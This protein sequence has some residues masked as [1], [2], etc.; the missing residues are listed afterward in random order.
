MRD[1]ISLILAMPKKLPTAKVAGK[2]ACS[3]RPLRSDVRGLILAAREQVARA[4]DSGLVTLYWHIGRR[5]HQDILKA[6]RAEYGAEI[7]ATLSRQLEAEFGRGFAEK[8]LRRMVQ[9]AEA[10]PDHAIL[11]SVTAKWR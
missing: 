7:V 5:V 4:V 8:N 6:R 3:V 11:Q 10:F 9:F 2:P 1:C